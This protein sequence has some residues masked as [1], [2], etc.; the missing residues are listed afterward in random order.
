MLMIKENQKIFN[1][2]FSL[3]NL[4]LCVLAMV[5]AYRMRFQVLGGMSS[6]PLAY[7]LRLMI[8]TVPFHFLV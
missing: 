3:L 2:L 6:V 4:I 7:Y 8:F 5:C 1:F